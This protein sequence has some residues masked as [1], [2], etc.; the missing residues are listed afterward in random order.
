MN[1]EHTESDN[2]TSTIELAFLLVHLFSLYDDHIENPVD[3]VLDFLLAYY[4][5]IP[6]QT[7][8]QVLS[9]FL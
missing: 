9:L 8:L 5:D 2:N 4:D 1:S 7:K 3:F 6:D